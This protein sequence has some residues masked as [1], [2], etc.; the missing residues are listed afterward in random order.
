M[1][2]TIA[3]DL[4]S[5]L[6]NLLDVWLEDYNRVYGDA[7]TPSHITTWDTHDHVKPECGTKVYHLLTGDLIKRTR[8]VRHS[9][10]VTR[11]MAAVGY[12]LVVVSSVGR[13]TYDAKREWL[14][15]Y[16]PHIPH[17][18][19]THSKG[20]V[21]CDVLIDD[22]VHNLEDAQRAGIRAICFNQPYNQSWQGERVYSWL[23]IARMFHA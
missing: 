20:L 22:G 10:A 11:D 9:V 5:T 7:L 14:K 18:I 6:N 13:G 16:F 1:P 21:R 3:I 12:T 4:D 17:F 8:P 19:A 15:E 2:A 23:D